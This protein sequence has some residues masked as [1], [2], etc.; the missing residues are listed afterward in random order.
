MIRRVFYLTSDFYLR[1]HRL[2]LQR[3]FAN[4]MYKLPFFTRKPVTY[5]RRK[6]CGYFRTI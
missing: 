5:K 4:E 3:L 6:K 2:T 1:I